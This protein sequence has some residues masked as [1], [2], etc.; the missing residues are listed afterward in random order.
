M[1]KARNWGEFEKAI[2]MEAVAQFNIVYSDIQGNI[3]W[4]SAGMFPIRST[5][6]PWKQPI[7]GTRSDLVWSKLLPYSEKPALFNPSCG[8]VFNCNQTPYN[9]SGAVNLF[10]TTVASASAK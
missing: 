9:C 7:P 4:Q 3:F 10:N 8:Y 2:R 6:I 5:A 1:N